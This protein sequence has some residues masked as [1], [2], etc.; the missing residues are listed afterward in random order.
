MDMDYGLYKRAR[1]PILMSLH[2]SYL[3]QRVAMGYPS[4]CYSCVTFGAFFLLLPFLLRSPAAVSARILRLPS[5]PDPKDAVGTA[6]WLAGQNIWGVLSTISSDQGGSPF[7]NVVSF[8]DGLPDDGRGIPYFYLT[9]LDPT[10]RDALKDARSSFTLSEHP[11][12]TC[13]KKD[14]EN[15]TCAKL[16]LTGK[17]KLVDNSS[18]E[19]QFAKNALFS[20]HPEMEDWPI[21]HNFKIFRLDI[22]NIFLIDWYGGAK[23]ITP[24]QYL[25]NGKNGSTSSS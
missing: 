20:K 3:M 21:G 24:P 4:S 23:P 6:R 7:G 10:A 19:I 14:P 13:G 18:A 5:K 11:L 17:L 1:Y 8:S 2:P 25:N 9:E 12:G 22:E 16:T 15:P